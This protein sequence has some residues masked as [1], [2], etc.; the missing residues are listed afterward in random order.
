MAVLFGGLLILAAAYRLVSTYAYETTARSLLARTPEAPRIWAH[1]VNSIGALLEAKSLFAGVEVDLVFDPR[2]QRF[3]VRHPP[4][5][6]TGLNL[7]AYLAAAADRPNLRLWLDWKNPRPDNLAQAMREFGRLDAKYRIRGRALV[8][9]PSDATF[10]EIVS[11]S[12]SGFRHGFYL[13]TERIAAALGQGPQATDRLGAELRATID[14]GRFGAVTYD[15]R[16][17]PFVDRELDRFLTAR[18]IHRFSWDIGINSGDPLTRAGTLSR[19]VR[20]RK[21]DALLIVFPSRYRV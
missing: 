15:A 20:E 9:T 10:P 8:E 19:T 17:Q 21:L 16:L 4:A 1:R 12:G 11:V 3:D 7:D 18:K 5:P 2:T 13:P 14:R 6:S